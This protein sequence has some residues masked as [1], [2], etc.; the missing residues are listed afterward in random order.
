MVVRVSV[1]TLSDFSAGHMITYPQEGRMGSGRDP[2][3]CLGIGY[4]NQNVV[5][6]YWMPD[7][8]ILNLSVVHDYD[9]A[10]MAAGS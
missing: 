1:I 3:V 6:R 2:R 4:R 10:P 9:P 7:H 5:D 8:Y